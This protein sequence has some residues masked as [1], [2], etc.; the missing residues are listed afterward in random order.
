M[1]QKPPEYQRRRVEEGLVYQTIQQELEP[2]LHDRRVHDRELPYFVERELRAYLR[3]GILRY[4]FCRVWCG[5]CRSD[6]VVPF[7]CKGRRRLARR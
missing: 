3:C 1:L 2:W 6:R 7:S 5:H 4:G